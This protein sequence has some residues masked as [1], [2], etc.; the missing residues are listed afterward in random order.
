MLLA[1]EPIDEQAKLALAGGIVIAVLG[2]VHG[3]VWFIIWRSRRKAAAAGQLPQQGSIQDGA[4]MQDPAGLP[5]DNPFLH[6]P[7]PAIPQQSGFATATTTTG[8][9]P[10]SSYAEI[11]SDKV[12]TV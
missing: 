8:F 4:N 2:L 10:A 11:S 7:A 9:Q 1:R 6:Q 5:G 3:V 12:D